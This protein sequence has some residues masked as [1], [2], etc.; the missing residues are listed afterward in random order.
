MATTPTT[1][2]FF[3]GRTP[4]AQLA[5]IDKKI[6]A[7]QAELAQHAAR[8]GPEIVARMSGDADAVGRLA[9]IDE[10]TKQL[11]ADLEDYRQVATELRRR[12]ADREAEAR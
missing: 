12:M 2:G 7:A 6:S 4:E 3:A 8:R 11:R 10:R 9:T 1:I 5:E